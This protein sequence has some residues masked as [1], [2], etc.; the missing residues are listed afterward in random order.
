MFLIK[1][2]GLALL[3]VSVLFSLSFE[4]V[5]Q[6]RPPRAVECFGVGAGFCDGPPENA[7]YVST[8]GSDSAAGT[9]NAPWRTLSHAVNSVGPGDTVLVA[10]GRYEGFR[11]FSRSGTDDQP[12]TVKANGDNV[13]LDR[14]LAGNRDIVEINGVSDFV[15]DGFIIR[16]A[17]RAGVAV[18]DADNVVISNNDIGPN[19]IWG[20]LTGFATNL[21]IINNRTFGSREQHGIYVSNSRVS[22]DNAIVRGN[23]VYSNHQNGIQFNGDCEVGGDGVITD[24]VIEGNRVYDNGWKGLSLISFSNS[25]VR[26]NI[27]Y[28]NGQRG[29]AGGIHLTNQPSC[30][31]PSN[32]NEV[33][34]NTL[35]EPNIAAVRITDGARDNRLFNN[36]AVSNTPFADE[37]G[38]NQIDASSN[39]TSNSATGLF[40]D[41]ANRN[42]EPV[43]TGSAFDSGLETYN[44]AIVNNFDYRGAFR[45]NG[46]AIDIGAVEVIAVAGNVTG[47]GGG[48]TGGGD[49]GGSTG[50]GDTGGSTGG[51]DT[52][53]STG[54]GDTGGGDTGGSTGGGDTGGSTGGTTTRPAAVPGSLV[55]LNPAMIEKL[56]GKLDRQEAP[57]VRFLNAANSEANG[58]NQHAF[59]A[60]SVAMLYHLTDERRYCDFAVQEIE[61]FVQSEEQLIANG[62]SPRVAFD[63][64]LYIGSHIGEVTRVYDWCREFVTTSQGQRWMNYANQAVANVWDHRNATWGGRSY[65][66]SG[67]STSNPMNNYHYSFLEATMLTGLV[68]RETS[69]T[70]AQR[71]MDKFRQGSIQDLIVPAFTEFSGGGSPEGTS[72]GDAMRELFTLYDWWEQST[73]EK[74]H[75]LTAH[76]ADSLQYGMHS[77]V[78]TLDY[79]TFLGDHAR[80]ST[81]MF[82]DY[83]RHYLLVAAELNRGTQMAEIS[84]DL[85][86]KSSLP[87]MRYTFMYVYD[88]IYQDIT[89]PTATID[90]LPN[91]YYA[92]AVGNLFKRDSW[93]S[94]S[95]YL[96]MSFGPRVESHD[97]MDKGSFQIFKGDW[98]AY[99]QNINT[100]NGLNASTEFYNL[101]RFN[102]GSS[103]IDQPWTHWDDRNSVRKPGTRP[104][105]VKVE[106]NDQFTH[107]AM[108]LAPL[109]ENPDIDT[110]WRELI[111]IR[112]GVTVVFDYTATSAGISK[113]WQLNSPYRPSVSGNQATVIG[114][115]ANMTVKTLLPANST[116]SIH[117]WAGDARFQASYRDST[118]TTTTGHR[119][120]VS[121]SNQTE[122]FLNV[123][124][125][126]GL[127]ESA[128][129]S[130]QNGANVLSLKLQGRSMM[131]FTFQNCCTAATIN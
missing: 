60:W 24:S 75:D 50:G 76:T 3:L 96:T 1:N 86:N 26:N 121:S 22:N 85:L 34:N 127:V 79:V 66:W 87:E 25:K 98:L 18:I 91:Y 68:Q 48:S 73:G 82:F 88:F 51:G 55:F 44:S 95:S 32:N 28:E 84:K 42:F 61:E 92:E 99:T 21:E 11:N 77:V 15:L 39:I 41:F 107:V 72:Y 115:S 31:Q 45:P 64:Y 131:T 19:Q 5:A 105:I 40:V 118:G 93:A 46:G 54:G 29:G 110:Y 12:I 35:Y 130:V 119:M 117:D 16:D 9:I 124:D 74:I 78:P 36:I 100:R 17:S 106:D 8:T 113:T 101:V 116:A 103:I 14:G 122:T 94:D 63:S 6:Q 10:D 90:Q 43:S 58:A 59:P 65:P 4:S 13:F 89:A 128:T 30:S 80:E 67:W 7:Y 33:Y 108:D 38:A 120:D 2:N 97:H 114:P 70:D 83:N 111:F 81:S 56:K 23:D 69:P 102:S 57:A 71:W 109:Y 62:G 123:I 20:I 53:G 126:E 129:V 27:I 49:T 104:N 47:G 37:V 112:P 52:G 125:T